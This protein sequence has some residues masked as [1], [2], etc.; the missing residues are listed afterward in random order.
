[1]SAER[2]SGACWPTPT[3]ELLLRAALWRGEEAVQAWQTWATEVDLGDLDQGSYRLVPL[4][5]RN[6]RRNGVAEPLLAKYKG[7]YRQ[8]WFKNQI[9]LRSAAALI[10]SLQSAGIPTL[11]LKGM[12]LTLLHYG[13]AGLRPM[14]DLDLLV[15][16]EQALAAIRVLQQTG[17][18]CTLTNIRSLD[19]L[20]YSR[21]SVEFVNRTEQRLDL[22][23][24]VLLDSREP[25]ADADFWT[26]AVHVKVNDA[27]ALALNAA[28]ELLHVC[29]HGA[30]WNP[31]PPLRWVADAVMI[32]RSAY[33]LDWERLIVQAQR[34]RLILP[35]RDT[36]HY[37]GSKMGVP[38]PPHVL[39][40]FASLATFATESA[41]YAAKLAPRH[42]VG[43]M[44]AV[45]YEYSRLAR[46]NGRRSDWLGFAEYLQIAWDVEYLWQVPFH[47]VARRAGKLRRFAASRMR[48]K[49]PIR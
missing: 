41:E 12:A 43:F 40:T 18:N 4:L 6:L 38:I 1:M 16:T 34:R 25:N 11:I 14:W 26:G 39:D 46:E 17:W 31:V 19:A 5:Y 28:D 42:V 37:L 10:T 24:H 2:S 13:D 15:P 9:L 27:P 33:G 36:L 21:H 30:R 29:V 47:A 7:I 32:I 44:P 22:H 8:T 45:W 20:I 35:M 3:Q 48:L 49:T 23:W